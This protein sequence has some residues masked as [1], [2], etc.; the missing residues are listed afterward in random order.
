MLHRLKAYARRKFLRVNTQKSEVVCFNSRTDSSPP[1]GMFFDKIFNL[2]SAAE[3]A[4]K[5]YVFMLMA[6][7]VL[8]EFGI[9]PNQFNWF[10]ATVRLVILLSIDCS[11]VYNSPL[12][13]KVF[14]ADMDLRSRNPSYWTSHLPFAMDAYIMLMIQI[15]CLLETIIC[16]KS[17]R[18]QAEH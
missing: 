3:E 15:F 5:S 16:L 9:E 8:C 11:V 1:L 6:L 18:P 17:S 13:Q 14:L 12:L 4:L 7:S 2:L 10:R